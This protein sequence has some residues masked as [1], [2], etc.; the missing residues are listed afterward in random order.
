MNDASAA[1]QRSH[2]FDEAVR[3]FAGVPPKRFATLLPHRDGPG[4]L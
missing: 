4:D 2:R 1:E 3:N